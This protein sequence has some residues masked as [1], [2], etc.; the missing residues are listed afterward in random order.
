MHGIAPAAALVL[1]LGAMVAAAAGRVLRVR[2][3]MADRLAGGVLSAAVRKRECGNGLAVDH[4]DGLETQYCHLLAGS[5]A[6]KPGDRVA[7]G[8]RLGQV[9]TSGMADFAHLHFRVRRGGAI[10]DPFTSQ[11]PDGTCRAPPATPAI[12]SGLWDAASAAALPCRGTAIRPCRPC[13][14]GAPRRRRA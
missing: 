9:G 6:V 10:V 11:R 7:R 5:M 14:A 13:G 8:A 2:D 1:W 4:G 12:A 3:G